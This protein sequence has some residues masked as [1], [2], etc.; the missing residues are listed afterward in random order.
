M[1]RY[2]DV[3]RVEWCGAVTSPAHAER[4][5]VRT[6]GNAWMAGPLSVK[7]KNLAFHLLNPCGEGQ[8]L[9][10]DDGESD[11]ADVK[12]VEKAREHDDGV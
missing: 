7:S 5:S 11:R 12:Q 8:R 4:W 1:S 6:V 9:I 10:C 2:R 3:V